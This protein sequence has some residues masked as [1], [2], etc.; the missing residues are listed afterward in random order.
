M[1]LSSVAVGSGYGL[2]PG[3]IMAVR[4]K[5]KQLLMAC[6]HDAWCDSVKAVETG[7]EKALFSSTTSHKCA[8]INWRLI[9]PYRTM[10]DRTC[11]EESFEQ[12][13]DVSKADHGAYALS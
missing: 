3:E 7:P 5:L 10:E 12:D 8:H 2:E 1:W 9:V 6:V 4:D 13:R 11:Y